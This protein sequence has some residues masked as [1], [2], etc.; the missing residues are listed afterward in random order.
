MKLLRSV[1]IMALFLNVKTSSDYM[2]INATL[3]VFNNPYHKLQ[4]AVG[5]KIGSK[6]KF[7]DLNIASMRDR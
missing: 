7:L 1:E 5:K 3:S 6:L 4:F 2:N